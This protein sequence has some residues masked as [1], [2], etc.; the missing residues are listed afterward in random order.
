MV[1]SLVGETG[2]LPTLR[3]TWSP[4][5]GIRGTLRTSRSRRLSQPWDSGDRLRGLPG[6]WGRRTDIR[7][8]MGRWAGTQDWMFRGLW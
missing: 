3:F 7:G 4:I 5:L 8:R 1:E 2:G 6:D